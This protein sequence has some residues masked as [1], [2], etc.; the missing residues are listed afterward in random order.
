M[1]IFSN[2]TPIIALS[3]IQ[4]LDLLPELFGQLHLVNEAE[5]QRGIELLNRHRIPLISVVVSDKIDVRN[6]D[7]STL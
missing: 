7:A 4:Q 1:I 2:T 3:S 6:F 5:T